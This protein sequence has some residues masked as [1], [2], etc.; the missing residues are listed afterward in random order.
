MC[1][2]LFA[3]FRDKKPEADSSPSEPQG[4]TTVEVCRRCLERH[5][6]GVNSCMEN[7]Y[8]SRSRFY[9]PPTAP[10]TECPHTSTATAADTTTN[11]TTTTATVTTTTS[12][13][14]FTTPSLPRT[15]AVNHLTVPSVR[16]RRLSSPV[17]GQ[18]RSTN[19]SPILPLNS[20]EGAEC[21]MH[22]SPLNLRSALTS[23]STDK[24]M[25]T[26]EE[27]PRPEDQGRT[28]PRA[29]SPAFHRVRRLGPIQR[30]GG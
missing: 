19:A 15:S 5:V 1:C 6:E 7:A 11:T 23:R 17:T 14:L 12:S 25:S 3:C 10:S 8:S 18:S 9:V 30:Q 2:V 29:S 4:T 16:P 21:G 27:C 28:S 20:R 24:D 13:T 26:M 22:R